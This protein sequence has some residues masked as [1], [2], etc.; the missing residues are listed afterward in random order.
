MLSVFHV[1]FWLLLNPPALCFIHMLVHVPPRPPMYLKGNPRFVSLSCAQINPS[2][3]TVLSTDLQPVFTS[4]F[5][6]PYSL[7]LTHI[8]CILSSG[9]VLLR[10]LQGKINLLTGV[11]TSA[12]TALCYCYYFR[13]KFSWF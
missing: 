11:S 13:V 7:P 9:P 1:D 2:L 4:P 6:T 3:I 5:P 8:H 10:I 12:Q